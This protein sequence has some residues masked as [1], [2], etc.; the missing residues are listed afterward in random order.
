MAISC[1]SK[2]RFWQVL[3]KGFPFE[4]AIGEQYEW[5]ANDTES[6]LGLV[7]KEKLPRGWVCVVFVRRIDGDFRLYHLQLGAESRK[8]ARDRLLEVMGVAETPETAIG[9][10]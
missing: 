2:R 4:G 1:M 7:A 9:T 10:E 6:I 8:A 5:W 3:P